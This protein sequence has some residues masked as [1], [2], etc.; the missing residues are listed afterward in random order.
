M[1]FRLAEARRDG[2]SDAD[3][4]A[5]LA[6]RHGFNLERARAD[7]VSDAEV[8]DYLAARPFPGNTSPPS[9]HP[10]ASAPEA[11]GLIERGINA[12]GNLRQRMQADTNE[13]LASSGMPDRPAGSDERNHAVLAYQARE[14]DAAVRQE[15]ETSAVDRA[16]AERRIRDRHIAAGRTK[17]EAVSDGLNAIGSGMQQI[18]AAFVG[19][20]APDSETA[21]RMER[22]AQANDGNLSPFAQARLDEARERIQAAAQ[23]GL[24]DEVKVAADEY[25][26]DPALFSYFALRTLPS[27][28]GVLG[29]AKLAQVITTL[30]G[31]S[32]AQIATATAATA[33][34]ANAGMTG[35]DARQQAYD[36][37]YQ[38]LREQGVPEDAA[39]TRALEESRLSAG[40]GMGLGWFGGKYGAEAGVLGLGTGRTAAGRAAGAFA[41]E[42]T[43]EL[44]EELAP[45][46]VTN[47]LASRIDGRNPLEG[48]GETA[49]QT[50][51]GVGPMATVGAVGAARRPG[52]QIEQHLAHREAQ[53]AATGDALEIA[54]VQAE[55]T[56]ARAAIAPRFDPS[57][58]ATAIEAQG[59]EA[60]ERI[61]AGLT[62]EQ[63]RAVA[64][65]LLGLPPETV[66]AAPDTTTPSDEAATIDQAALLQRAHATAGTP[67]PA[68]EEATPASASRQDLQFTAGAGFGHQPAIAPLEQTRTDLP[69]PQSTATAT[70]ATAPEQ[71]APRLMSNGRPFPS[72]KLAA[73]S[74][75]QRKL[76]MRAVP[77][78]GG[79]GLVPIEQAPSTASGAPQPA[80]APDEAPTGQ[81]DTRYQVV[82][83]NGRIF[84]SYT[85]RR[86][87]EGALKRAGAG[88]TLRPTPEA[89]T[90]TPAA[91]QQTADEFID[92]D[93]VRRATTNRADLARQHFDAVRAAVERGEPV[94]DRVLANYSSIVRP[95]LNDDQRDL[96]LDQ[97]RGSTPEEIVAGWRAWGGSA[98]GKPT[99]TAAPE[100]ARAQASQMDKEQETDSPLLQTNGRPFKNAR[101]AATSAR[102]RGFD[103]RPVRVE[104]GWGLVPTAQAPLPKPWAL[105]PD[106][107]LAF[108]QIEREGKGWAARWDGEVLKSEPQVVNGNLG[109]TVV[110]GARIFPTRKEAEAVARLAHR[111]AVEAAVA[112][113][114]QVAPEALAQYPEL[115][116]PAGAAPATRPAPQ[117]EAETPRAKPTAPTLTP[118][119]TAKGRDVILAQV[120]ALKQRTAPADLVADYNQLKDRIA[121]ARR[122]AS[123]KGTKRNEAARLTEWADNQEPELERLRKAI[124]FAELKA[125]STRYRILNTPQNLEAFAQKL[126]KAPVGRWMVTVK[127]E[128]IYD[129]VETRTGTTEAQ[130][131]RGRSAIA[132]LVDRVNARSVRD[133]RGSATLLGHRLLESFAGTG[134]ADLVGQ[135]VSSAE[136]LATLAQ[137]FRDPRFETFRVFYTDAQ[138]AIVG[139]AAYSSRLPAAVRLPTDLEARIGADMERFGGAGFWVLHNHPSGRAT[140]SQSDVSLTL[141][142]AQNVAGFQGHVVIDHNEYATIDAAGEVSVIKAPQLNGADFFNSP[143]R[144]HALL[145]TPLQGEQDVVKAAKAL[146]VSDGHAALILTRR[147]GAVQLL[148]D[149]PLAMLQVGSS[150]DL[151]KLK[152]ALRGFAR[153]SGSGGHRF[154]VLPAG[155]SPQPFTKLVTTGLFTDVVSA[156]GT[157]AG[158]F[159]AFWTGDFLDANMPVRQVKEDGPRPRRQTESPEFKTWFG[160]SK[161]VDEQGEPLVV[162]H[163]TPTGGFTQFDP[164]KQG[165]KGGH[166]R[167]GFSFTTDREAAQ[168]YAKGFSRLSNDLDAMAEAANAVLVS[169]TPPQELVDMGMADEGEGIYPIEPANVDTK[170]DMVEAIDYYAEVLEKAGQ[171][172]AAKALLAAKEARAGGK[173]QVYEV[174]L[175]VPAEAPEFHAT[176][177]TLGQVVAGLDVRKVPGRAAVVHLPDGNRVFYVADPT[178]IKSAR[179]NGGSFDPGDANITHDPASPYQASQPRPNSAPAAPPAETR[180]RA[181]QRRTQDKFNRFTVIQDWLKAR[182][183]NLTEQADVYRAEERMHG[184]AATRIEDFREKRLKPIVEKIRKAGFNMAEV[185]DFLHAQ[186]AEERNAQIAKINSEMPDGGAGMTNAEAQAKLAQ[187]QARPELVALANELRAITDDTKRVL[188]EAGIITKE[189][190]DAWGATYQHYVPLKGGPDEDSASQGTGRGLT[191]K[192]KNKRAL[193]HGTREE[194]IIENILRDHER[195]ILQAEKNRVGQHLLT[196]AIEAGHEELITIGQPVKR[197]VLK[198]TVH[199]EVRYHG[200]TVE[201]FRSLADAQRFVGIEAL[202]P[203]RSKKDFAIQASHDLDVAMMP[204][205]VLEPNETQVYVAGHAVRVQFKDEGLAR[206]WNNLGAESFNVVMRLA[207]EVNTFLSRAYTG[208][209]PEFI[210]VNVFRDLGTGVLNL[211]GEEGGRFALT[212]LKNYPRAFAEL[213]KYAHTGNPSNW[214]RQYRADGGTTGAAYLS[215]LERIGKD[216]QAAYDEAAGVI[217]TWRNGGSYRAAR[218]AVREILGPFV[219]W[220]EKLNQAGENAMRLA[221]YRTAVEMGQSRARAAAL[222]KNSTVNFNRQGELGQT[223]GSLYLFAN[224]AIQGTASIV[225]ALFKGKHKAQAHALTGAIVAAG[226]TMAA[227]NG[228]GPEDEYEKLPEF[229][230]ERFMPIWTGDGWV[231]IP[232]PYG[233]G[234]F[235]TM[236]RQ[237]VALEKGED[238]AKVSL[239]LAASFVEEF[240]V[241]G[242]AADPEGDEKNVTFL[243]P[244]IPQIVMAP[245]INRTGL[246]APVY[247]ESPFDQS[248]PD[249]LKMWRTTQGTVFHDVAKGLNAVTGGDAVQ[250]GWIDVSPE[251]LRYL[252]TTTTG[253]TGRFFADSATLAKNLAFEGL[254]P[255]DVESREVPI[256]RKFVSPAND[257]RGARARFWKAAEE[258]RE[259]E[260]AFARAKRLED[261]AERSDLTRQIAAE[262]GELLAL[263]RAL[264]SWKRAIRA[265]R[266]L[267][268]TIMADESRTL[269][270][271]RAMVREIEIRERELYDG[272]VAQFKQV[273]KPER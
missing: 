59:V 1:T 170:A 270:E 174:F 93:I 203:G 226:Y 184:R 81:P 38:A 77:V 182:G 165:T 53:A 106:D 7:G 168:G 251:T 195:A 230:K 164:A 116:T 75:R 180:A 30:R 69:L 123:L 221:A 215:D 212:A 125:G 191:V 8:A 97:V 151:G 143:E 244:T 211:T 84:G 39:R 95:D 110:Q 263:G 224:P 194:W 140:P 199:Y 37:I 245:I 248:K 11:P 67:T 228:G 74:A 265:E 61:T 18:P 138:G 107:F 118:G 204:S 218:A 96:M 177:E 237:V 227:L 169:I 232:I 209:N 13:G 126:K 60:T 83:P 129:N 175:R 240:S 43:T 101:L 68:Q 76:D 25:L 108:V 178:Q 119:Q 235:A 103:M 66:T 238:P 90:D 208:W 9:T 63:K 27:M 202:K 128:E 117:P 198:D 166:A 246:G 213:L 234:F 137:V 29:P 148:M 214:I 190:A 242:A 41:G 147:D 256:A 268:D 261:L 152:G 173:P 207:R 65:H 78:E 264:G 233:Y 70:T 144:D 247:P 48:L 229:Q 113:G 12:V 156:D 273:A 102:Q 210:L 250:K 266:D 87:A 15:M 163:G 167:G 133:G 197:Q 88:A 206:A 132:A 159:G 216:V 33:G 55:N 112:R 241:W 86:D 176:P 73:T 49:V 188:L 192:Q 52:P 26:T 6:R 142:V 225:H 4:A 28:L 121:D 252:W 269:T 272:F 157:T 47:S 254:S 179:D 94:P 45:Q 239:R 109:R 183:I 155:M 23:D 5:Y 189:M 91:W 255:T 71:P 262:S 219:R 14:R 172:D 32:A 162:Y 135:T 131:T 171:A 196:L 220:I 185:A 58:I 146:Q 200:S 160:D 201:V 22:S 34:A 51:A 257:I 100:A 231:K 56:A 82:L 62:P 36:T 161:A 259:A 40:V 186:H 249:N 153:E 236:G 217:Q 85:A 260:E 50:V 24:W 35:G 154:I 130:R 205:P 2:H 150:K 136:D 72:E 223:I 99:S 46:L 104:G 243:L 20:F 21:E 54:V 222:A 16:E 145:G 79:W 111:K 141:A 57:N 17:T 3:I 149:V 139:E 115:S 127:P 181:L 98:Q 64:R 134:G 19:L 120:E 271:R 10:P 253:G 44:A 122:R 258:V 124:G 187:Y 114:E 42:T 80:P 105:S 193:G 92:S 158:N 31:A 267:I 89:A